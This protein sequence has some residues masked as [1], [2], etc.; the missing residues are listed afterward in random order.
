VDQELYAWDQTV[1]EDLGPLHRTIQQRHQIQL[2]H[3]S[4]R[5]EES[6]I[7]WIRRYILFYNKRHPKEMGVPEIEAFLSH[8]AVEGKISAST[9]NQALSSL[10]TPL[11]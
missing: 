6:Y 9:Q 1:L 5:T 4:Y 3:C 7:Q 2:K 10:E 8:L 11:K